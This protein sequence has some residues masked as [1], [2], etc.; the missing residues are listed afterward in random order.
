MFGFYTAGCTPPTD[1]APSQLWPGLVRRAKQT[2]V[3]LIFF[4]LPG[5]LC[6]MDCGK[7]APSWK[8]GR[9]PAA[10]GSGEVEVHPAIVPPLTGE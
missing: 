2:L 4:D 8:S 9:I 3:K 1:A 7:L 6:Y 5:A 10:A